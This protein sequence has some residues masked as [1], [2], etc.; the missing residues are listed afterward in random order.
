[1]CLSLAYQFADWIEVLALFFWISGG[2][3]PET[4]AVAPR[5]KIVVRYLQ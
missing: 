3:I 4:F 2:N 1:M 5:G